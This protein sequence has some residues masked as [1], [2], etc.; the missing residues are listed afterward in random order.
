MRRVVSLGLIF[1]VFVAC[2]ALG[3]KAVRE[4]EPLPAPAVNILVDGA[5]DKAADFVDP[6]TGCVYL[7]TKAGGVT[8]RLDGVGRPMCRGLR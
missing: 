7:M 6:A 2:A 1:A 3:L 8:P 5:T 4:G